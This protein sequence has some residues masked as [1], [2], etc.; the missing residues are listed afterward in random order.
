[1]S[2]FLELFNSDNITYHSQFVA[3]RNC[4]RT[5]GVVLVYHFVF[6]LILF[7]LSDIYDLRVFRV[8]HV[9]WLARIVSWID[10]RWINSQCN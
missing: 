7:K 5:L 4:A 1:M 9:T 8:G 3:S 6:Q 2:F 10:Q